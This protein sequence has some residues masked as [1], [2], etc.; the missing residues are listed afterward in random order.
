MSSGLVNFVLDSGLKTA[1]D[2][3][4]R[5]NIYSGAQPANADAAATG[6]LLATLSMAATGIAAASSGVSAWAAITSDTN[7]DASATAGWFRVY[8]AADDPSGISTVFRRLDGA[9]PADLDFDS[10]TFVAGGTAAISALSYS[11]VA[12]K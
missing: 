6:T 8:K 10:E 5:I 9:I 7:V 2:S 1:F 4:G 12:W 11:G 3:D